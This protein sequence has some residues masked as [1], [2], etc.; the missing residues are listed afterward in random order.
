MKI[1]FILHDYTKSPNGGTKVVYEY[2]RYLSEKGH[3]VCIYYN[4]KYKKKMLPI[5][6]CKILSN[7]VVKYWKNW[8]L[9][10][11]NTKRENVYSIHDA[12]IRDA[13]A[14]IATDIRTAVPVSQLSHVKGRKFY[15]IQDFENWD[16]D[17]EYV[18]NTYKLGMKNIVVSK[19]LKDVVESNSDTAAYLLSNS[20]DSSIFN[21]NKSVGERLEHTI[22]FHY[23]SGAYKGCKYAIDVVKRMKDKYPDL[24]VAVVG[25]EERP[26]DLPDFCQYYRNISPA[27]VA[28][29]NNNSTV[30]LCTSVKEGFGLPGLEAMACGCN[31]V[32]TNY[33]GVREYAI[34][35][36]N[37]LLVDI[38][39]VDALC[40]SIENLF[41]NRLL[42]ERLREMAIKTA[43]ERTIATVGKKLE[44]I[45]GER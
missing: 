5:F 39:D 22:T 34:D 20:I 1:N 37:S 45:L 28:A 32:S 43:S 30:F 24:N 6:V 2:S 19:W 9:F 3:D 4:W 41:E 42:S 29:I 44:E 33:E 23:R 27:E 8:F 12:N 38:G 11:K 35:G 10:D 17:D 14:V 36:I 16:F 40:A 21:I 13:D 7:F 15:L 31:L 25:R 26:Q 18:L